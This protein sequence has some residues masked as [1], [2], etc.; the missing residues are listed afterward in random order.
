MAR[1]SRPASRSRFFGRGRGIAAAMAASRVRTDLPA[2]LL[3]AL[4]VGGAYLAVLV[5]RFDARVPHEQLERFLWF[6]PVAV[7]AHVG[8]C[9]ASGLYDEM[10]RH[11]S[12][13]EARRLV[14]ANVIAGAALL[15]L[16]ETDVLARPP[17]TVLVLGPFVCMALLGCVRFQSRL[18]AVNRARAGA[19]NVTR[20][21]VLGAGSA[22]ASLVRQMQHNIGHGMQPVVLLDDDPR[23]L[24]RHLAGVPVRGTLDD[25]DDVARR[26]EVEQAV[27]AIPSADADVVRRVAVAAEAAGVPLRVLPPM[28]DLVGGKA[29]VSDVRDLRIEDLLGRDQVETDYAEVRRLLA[30]RRVLITGAGGSIGSEIARQVASFGPARLVLLEHDETHLHDVVATV[31]GE[32]VTA[33]ADIRDR[34]LVDEIFSL[35]RPEVVFH[36]AAHKHVPL[37]EAHPC[38]AVRTNVA[39]TRNVVDAAR[40]HGVGRF[41]FISTDK[42]VRPSSVMGASKWL[43]EQL[44][45]AA[46]QDAGGWCAV[47]FG[48]VLGSR[49]SVIPT[50]TRQIADGGPVTVT[51]ENMTR[52]F[53]S[54]QEAVQLVL[55]AAAF[56]SGG[57]VFMLE[58]GSP[59]R[60]LELAERMI[61]LSGHR[62]GVDI[63]IAITGMR[64]GEKLAEELRTADEHPLPTPHPSIVRLH[65]RRLDRGALEDAFGKLLEMASANDGAVGDHLRDLAGTVSGRPDDAVIDLVALER[66]REVS[67]SRSST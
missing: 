65:P 33:L 37:L 12:I 19:A 29:K 54:V 2:M 47:R 28:R 30:G 14:V 17:L 41:V 23:K 56:A 16:A 40:A 25:L 6:L 1:T 51:D 35:H 38:E 27:L 44:V 60:I 21:A 7:V 50:F 9:R 11:A 45:L 10:W 8:L 46:G 5:L 53:M 58:M 49:G 3:D 32:V 22:G 24:Q 57:E 13:T 36:A 52:F 26:F 15:L 63:E 48:N 64:P 39:G 61:E 20:V 31:D 43:G 55:Q 42:A 62:V 66:E 59:M 67:W 18:F 34:E 4:L